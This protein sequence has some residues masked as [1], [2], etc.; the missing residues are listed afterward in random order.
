MKKLTLMPVIILLLVQS[1]IAGGIVTNTNQSAAWIRTLVRDASTGIDAVYYNPAGLMKLDNGFH[2]SLN[3]QAIFQNKD[4]S[5]SFPYLSHN[6]FNGKVTAPVFPGIYA[7]YKM[8]KLAFSFGFNPIGGGGGAKFDRGLPSFEIPIA[9]LVPMLQGSLAPIDNAV[10]SA[11]GADPG[12]RNVSGYNANILFEGTSVYFGFQLGASYKINDVISIAVGGR[13]IMSKNTYNGYLKDIKINAPASYGGTQ[14]PG[15]YLRTVAGAIGGY[16]PGGAAV[17]NGTAAVIDAK[18]ADVKVDAV[19]KGSGITPFIG[20]NISPNE[21]LNIGLKY[22]MPTKIELTNET[23]VDGTG[24]FPDKKVTRG[25]MPAMFSVGVDYQAS[26]KLSITSGLHYYFDKPAYYGKTAMVNNVAVQV[27]NEDL[28]DNNYWEIGLGLEYMLGEKL[29]VSAGYLR[30]QTGVNENY[31]TDL[32]FSLSSNT[33]GGG[34]FYALTEK[35]MLNLGVAYT[36]Y[37]DGVKNYT[38]NLSQT[39]SVPYTN[40]FYKDNLLMAIG[41]DI[42]F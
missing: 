25:D 8:D 41:L 6:E 17:L 24:M 37:E 4:V 5:N 29:G 13:Y 14:S 30:A 31:Q 23:V 42:S 20:V 34:I 32:S 15:N 16:N 2:L 21:D 26:T 18:T 7:A 36:K 40:T 39:V 11:T 12:F 1:A 3:S 22:E 35:M 27:N 28:I 10:L 9:A 38:Y 19:Q 33:V